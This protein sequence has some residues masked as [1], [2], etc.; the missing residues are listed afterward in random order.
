MRRRRAHKPL[1]WPSSRWLASMPAQA[2]TAATVMDD[3][4]CRNPTTTVRPRP[5]KRKDLHPCACMP[6]SNRLVRH[7]L[8]SFE[9]YPQEFSARGMPASTDQMNQDAIDPGSDSGLSDYTAPTGSD[10]AISHERWSHEIQRF[11]GGS[12]VRGPRWHAGP[13]R[14]AGRVASGAVE[15]KPVVSVRTAALAGGRTRAPQ[16]RGHQAGAA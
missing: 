7:A 16:T 2:W 3:P 10:R 6:P 11:R 4:H 15:T 8:H 9:V 5:A 12:T 1:R 14:R 13:Q